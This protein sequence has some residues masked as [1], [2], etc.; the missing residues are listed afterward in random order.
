[1]ACMFENRIMFSIQTCVESLLMVR[2]G[3][4][5]LENILFNVYGE[6]YY[7]RSR[8]GNAIC[9]GCVFGHGCV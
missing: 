6:L 1:M 8:G 2:S 7:I 9:H 5:A 4:R 3:G